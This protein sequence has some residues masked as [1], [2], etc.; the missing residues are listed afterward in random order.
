MFSKHIV[1]RYTQSD[2]MHLADKLSKIGG[3]PIYNLV[4]NNENGYHWFVKIAEDKYLDILGVQ[5]GEQLLKYWQERRRGIIGIAFYD[6]EPIEE[7]W[8]D[9]WRFP[10]SD[11]LDLCV[12][13]CVLNTYRSELK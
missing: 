8:T 2:C 1:D 4:T 12:A 10:R 6:N 3:W 7:L 9:T 5:T 13:N 11:F